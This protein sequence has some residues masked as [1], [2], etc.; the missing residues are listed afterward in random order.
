MLPEQLLKFGLSIFPCHPRTKNPLTS[1]LPLKDPPEFWENGDPK[2]TWKPFQ[3]RFVDASERSAWYENYPLCNW[4]IA[5]GRLS[6]IV[7]LDVDNPEGWEFC[8]KAGLPL[9]VVVNTSITEDGFQKQQYY[10]RHPGVRV[11]NWVKGEA[12]IPGCD[13]RG[14]G[15]YVMAPGSIHPS[16]SVYTFVFS[17]EDEELA[18]MPEWLLGVCRE[19]EYVKPVQSVERAE[20]S[21]QGTTA[22]VE[23]VFREEIDKL[24]A[25]PHGGRNHQLF[26]SV[27][28]LYEFESHGLSSADIDDAAEKA[29]DNDSTHPVNWAN[30]RGT[31]AS[32]RTQGR[33]TVAVI[34]ALM[35]LPTRNGNGH[36]PPDTPIVPPVEAEPETVPVFTLDDAGNGARFAWTHRNTILYDHSQSRWLIWDE[37]RY[38][39]DQKLRIREM[40][41]TLTWEMATAATGIRDDLLLKWAAKSRG[42]EKLSAM[43]DGAKSKPHIAVIND[44]LDCNPWL[45]NTLS[46]TLDLERGTVNVGH[47]YGDRLTKIAPVLYDPE[48]RECP[49][50]LETIHHFIPDEHLRTYIQTRL[51]YALTGDMGL[52]EFYICCGPGANGKS[53]LLQ[54]VFVSMLGDYATSVNAGTFHMRER[55][56][57]PRAD[58]MSLIGKRLVIVGEQN[59]NRPL[60]VA[61][62]KTITGEDEIRARTPH[63]PDDVVYSP[64]FKIFMMTNPLPE[65]KE[66][67]HAIWRRLKLLLFPVIMADDDPRRLKGAIIQ[68]RLHSEFTG[69][70]NWALEGLRLLREG[71]VEEPEAVKLAVQEYRSQSDTMANFFEDGFEI[72]GNLRVPVG[73][74]SE[75][76]SAWCRENKIEQLTPPKFAAKMR[77]RG[78][79][80]GKTGAVRYWYGLSAN[81]SIEMSLEGQNSVPPMS[82]RD[83]ESD[84]L[85]SF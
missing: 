83:T 77:D 57:G 55:D 8:K 19:K 50:F 67:T 33:K 31:I 28:R 5:T 64:K 29:V 1:A 79:R 76:Y 2:R 63:A 48:L 41:E 58:L 46:G 66:T 71:N 34:P 43:I 59:E 11:P 84:T 17:I 54:K 40:A 52:Q 60:D 10:F 13:F 68:D 82:L 47:R 9:T 6:C 12:K 39:E 61:L 3:E 69:I 70:L 24:R 18:D 30:V 16:G 26:K 73:R 65:V 42:R 32:A 25:T 22:Y 14:D 23:K 49:T 27:T 7:V 45:L 72:G 81:G 44:E 20:N 53:T 56:H 51:G 15:G 80:N 21:S 62:A 75:L 36:A 4:A 85:T 37:K 35:M 74:V 38:R 78:F